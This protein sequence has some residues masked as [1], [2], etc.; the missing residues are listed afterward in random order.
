MKE[1]VT[2]MS[3]ALK[4]L[5][6]EMASM[7]EG[8]DAM[9]TENANLRRNVEKLQAE[10]RT[11]R[12]QLEKYEGPKKNSNNSSTPPSKEPMKDEVVRR[13]KSLRKKSGLKPGGQPGHEGHL[14]ELVAVPDVMEECGRNFCRECGRDLSDAERELDYV[15]QAVD[16]PTM[17]PVVTEYRH[18]KKVC[19]CGCCNKGY[20]ARK[21][22][23]QIVFGR[24]IRA[25]VTYLNVV[26]R[27]PYERLASLMAEVFSVHM[28]QGTIR[29]IV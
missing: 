21:R 18:Y 29:N 26:Q 16:L 25:I 12:K 17:A 10:N 8:M 2:D 20:A 22:G 9:R 6:S 27:V 23:S 19:T 13:T 14:K 28:S 4:R 1:Q 7:R 24:N 11:L 3:Q 5:T 15:S